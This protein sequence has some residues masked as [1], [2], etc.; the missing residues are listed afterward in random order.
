M[1]EVFFMAARK[2]A[3]RSEAVSS[4]VTPA[5]A[6]KESSVTS[7][8]ST[9]DGLSVETDDTVCVALNRPLGVYFR[10][11]DGRKV[12]LNG[13]G[14][15]LRGKEKGVLP[16]GAYGMTV[17]KK[18]DWEYILKTY[19]NAKLFKN[20]LLFA[21]SSR[22]ESEKEADSRDDLRNGLEPV[23]P[24]RTATTEAKGE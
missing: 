16:V 5:F 12:T 9:S 18:S 10:M 23:D 19:G 6:R 7:E 21:T 8:K 13:N 1:S 20:G 4:T 15:P 24:A 3:E 2:S 14:A 17:I 22:A 11:P